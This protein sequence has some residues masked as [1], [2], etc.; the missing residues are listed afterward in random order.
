MKSIKWLALL[1]GFVLSSHAVASCYPMPIP[2]FFFCVLDDEGLAEPV[3]PDFYTCHDDF[4][5]T[6]AGGK[7]IFDIELFGFCGVHPGG[8]LPGWTP[9]NWKNVTVLAR[10]NYDTKV[11]EE[12]L[13][14]GNQ[15]KIITHMLCDQNPW[16]H[17]PSCTLDG[18][19]TNN[20]SAEVNGPFPFSAWRISYG[21][22]TALANWE[23][24]LNNEELLADWDPYAGSGSGSSSLKIDNPSQYQE[25]P[26]DASQFDLAIS[27]TSGGTPPQNVEMRW[28]R[29]IPAPSVVGDIALPS[30][31]THWWEPFFVMPFATWVDFPI[32]VSVLPGYFENQPGLYEVRV[33]DADNGA[34]SHPARFWIGSPAFDPPPLPSA[35]EYAMASAV[36][37]SIMDTSQMQRIANA[38]TLTRNLI[39]PA[40]AALRVVKV[41]WDDDSRPG[42]DLDLKITVKNT[43]RR[44]S[45]PNRHHVYV[46]CVPTADCP[47]PRTVAIRES[48]P[49]DGAKTIVIRRALKPRHGDTRF[50]VSTHPMTLGRFA[51][52]PAITPITQ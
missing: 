44:A 20:T 43:G 4:E 3:Q 45:A 1:F 15:E 26:E 10:Y 35:G 32:S 33:R 42:R 31:A 21:L 36:D 48:I 27:L 37:Q 13:W 22:R 14:E 52:A 5:I 2:P 28:E 16:A 34:W 24:T 50:F 19:I 18:T 29:I 23:S 46:A 41:T 9:V 47:E 11:T 51:R 8:G 38:R 17:T 12:T 30:N 39:V 25:I 7:P 49:P 40:T 6:E